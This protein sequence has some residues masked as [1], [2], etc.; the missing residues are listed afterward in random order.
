MNAQSKVRELIQAHLVD[1]HHADVVRFVDQL[2]PVV[3]EAGA[4]K[5]WQGT[6]G[7][8]CFQ[9]GGQPALEV[10]LGRAKTKLR[11]LCARLAVVCSERTGQDI[12]IFGGEASLEIC[13][14]PLSQ[15]E[16]VC[17]LTKMHVRFKNNLA[18]PQGFVIETI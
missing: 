5:C 14:P 1:N 8:L 3:A 6:D 13:A 10:E 4:I 11:M 7:T 18:E 2:F 9:V 16:G 15:S 12:S 17:C